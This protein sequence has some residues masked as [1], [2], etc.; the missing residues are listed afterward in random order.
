MKQRAVTRAEFLVHLVGATLPQFTVPQQRRL[1][2]GLVEFCRDP[3]EALW[4]DMRPLPTWA[5]VGE[6][7]RCV[8]VLLEKVVFSSFSERIIAR[9]NPFDIVMLLTSVMLT[10]NPLPPIARCADPQCPQKL[11]IRRGKRRFCHDRCRVRAFVRTQR[12]EMREAER[13]EFEKRKRRLSNG[14]TRTKRKARS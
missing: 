13:H 4:G 1:L 7:Q 2:T 5:D 10:Q 3:R 14:L 11:F 12:A 6:I 8:R 9:S